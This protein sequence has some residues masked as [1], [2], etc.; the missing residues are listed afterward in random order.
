M[1]LG[2]KLPEVHEYRVIVRETAEHY[3]VVEAE[4]E[5]EAKAMA[6]NKASLSASD[7]EYTVFDLEKVSE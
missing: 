4:S 3:V 5:E 6:L 2:Q 1:A 7:R